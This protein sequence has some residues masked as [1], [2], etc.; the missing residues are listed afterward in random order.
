M[1]GCSRELYRRSA[2][3][4]RSVGLTGIIVIL[5]LVATVT[6]TAPAAGEEVLTNESIIEL[7]K[8]GF[9]EDVLIGKIQST[10]CNFDVSLDG[11]KALK[12]A[13]IPD[14]VIRKMI[15][16]GSP[17]TNDRPSQQPVTDP[18]DPLSPQSPG[19]YLFDENS[20]PALTKI[21][22][23]VYSQAKSGGMWKTAL[24]YGAAKTKMKA[25]LAGPT[26]NLSISNSKPVF[27]FYFEEA[28]S[29]LSYQ[30]GATTSPNEFILAE[31]TVN[32]KKKSRELVVGQFNYYGSQ[33]GAIDK[34][35]RP[36]DFERL[37]PGI[38]R[39]TP[40]EPLGD[41]EYGFYYA[42]STPPTAYGFYG[43]VGGTGGGKVFDFSI[44]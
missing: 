39:V 13:E 8:M 40:K 25:V 43:V 23:S 24:T 4:R 6:A 28:E 16:A 7:H 27:Y 37:A 11:L 9:G 33:S 26:A 41:G 21:E 31:F 42:G 20:T 32:R 18:N 35:V 29:G 30:N 10:G 2:T 15:E 34:T 14:A 19:I 3:W 44:R 17:S 36:F 12:E 38:Y 22:P 1:N 5:A